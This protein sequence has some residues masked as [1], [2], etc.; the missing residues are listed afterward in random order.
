MVTIKEMAQELGVSTTTVSNVIHG[1][2]KEVSPA[3]VERIQKILKKY[4]Y[5]P[6]IN[7]RNLASRRS[8]II[9]LVVKRGFMKNQNRFT[10]QF[11]GGILGAVE[12]RVREKGYYLMV[13]SVND[14]HQVQQLTMSWNMDGLITSGFVE[15]DIRYLRE[16]YKHP[17]AIIDD[18]DTNGLENCANIRID[19]RKAEYELTKYVIGCGHRKIVFLADNLVN[20]D[21]QRF[22]GYCAAMEEAGI[23]EEEQRFIKIRN[24]D[25]G[26]MVNEQEIYEASFLYTAFVCYSDYYASRIMNMLRDKGRK[27]PEDVSIAG[28]DD[29]I[30]A[31]LVRPALTTVRQNIEK[32]GYAAVDALIQLIEEGKKEELIIQDTE[33]VIRDSVKKLN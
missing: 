3:N 10:D 16:R 14:V 13:Y 17:I 31:R 4:D 12:E 18:Y 24:S 8:R 23:P 25:K 22:L 30:T 5:T 21:R 1:K 26:V 19:D 6:N 29:V 7:A 20:L 32:K 2:T 28:F 11:I 33:L 15:G 27:I 9:G